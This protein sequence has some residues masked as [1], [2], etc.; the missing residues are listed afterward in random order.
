MA[1][2]NLNYSKTLLIYYMNNTRTIN[3][4]TLQYPET[5]SMYYIITTR[6]IND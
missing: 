5:L 4:K 1:D 6:T 2:R 3:D